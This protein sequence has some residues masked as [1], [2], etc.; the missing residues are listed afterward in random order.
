MKKKITC[1]LL[2]LS[3]SVIG[4]MIG[5][6]IP[7]STE[8]EIYLT[9]SKP[10]EKTQIR[11][12]AVYGYD[13]AIVTAEF[14]YNDLCSEYQILYKKEGEDWEKAKIVKIE[15][16]PT[17]KCTLECTEVLDSLESGKTYVVKLVSFQKDGRITT[18]SEGKILTM[19]I[20][21]ILTIQ[22]NEAYQVSWNKIE[23][24]DRYHLIYTDRN[25]QLHNAYTEKQ[26]YILPDGTKSVTVSTESKD[27]YGR[28]IA[29]PNSKPYYF[30]VKNEQK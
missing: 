16:L 17:A 11:S 23:G 18:E 7:E 8:D 9:L 3:I 12:L 4:Y 15:D 24:V 13:K 20:S 21:G 10:I 22:E 29:G 26:Q 25:G 6:Q 30:E 28:Y 19:P 27:S 5:I 2:F 14:V 1:I